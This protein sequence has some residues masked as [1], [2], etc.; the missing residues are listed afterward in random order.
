M[1][2]Y[3]KTFWWFIR[4]PG[5]VVLRKNQRWKILWGY[6]SLTDP[7][8]IKDITEQSTSEELQYTYVRYVT[9]KKKN[10]RKSSSLSS[11][12]ECWIRNFPKN[13][14]RNKTVFGFIHNTATN[15]H[16]CQCCGTGTLR[17]RVICGIRI[18]RGNRSGSDLSPTLWKIWFCSRNSW[19]S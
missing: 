6:H 16:P 2:P 13:R 12:H 4:A 9:V 1:K 19:N 7:K 15:L 5:K 14:I 10:S 11:E 18:S 3:S 8:I 17:I